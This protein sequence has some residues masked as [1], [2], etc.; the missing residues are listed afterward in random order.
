MESNSAGVSPSVPL[1]DDAPKEASPKLLKRAVTA[2]AMGNATEWFDYGVYAYLA[3][4]IGANFFPGEHEAL[5]A[6]LGLAVS[7]VL[8]PLGGLV[9]GP[10]GDR[11]GRSKVLA[12]TILLM[13]SATFLMGLLPT[14]DQIGIWA[15]ILLILLRVVQGFSTG[16]EYGGAATFMAEYAPDKKRGFWGSFLEF[17]T[18][19]GLTAGLIIVAVLR[20]FLG[21][22]AM[23]DWGWRIPFLVAGPL[24]GIG[25]YLRMKM[26][27]TPVFQELSESGESEDEATGALKNLLKEHW[28]PILQLFGLVIALNVA[29]YLLLTYM[30]TYLP[31]TVGMSKGNAEIMVLIGQVVM[32]ILLPMAGALSDRIGR[33]PCWWISLIG[34]FVLSVPMFWL[35]GKGMVLAVIGFTVLGA[36]YVLQ[37]G[38]ISATFPAMFPSHVR[39]AGMAISYN[40][41]TAAFGGTAPAINEALIGA[42]GNPLIPAFYMMAACAV[43]MVALHFVIETKGASLRGRGVPGVLSR[44]AGRRPGGGGGGLGGGGTRPGQLRPTTD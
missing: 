31:N 21:D 28:K 10:L 20:F 12:T 16:G 34:L 39:Y 37:L 36:I 30:P 29:N 4:E 11:L 23:Q 13:C 40:V 42:T 6:L 7:F 5:G 38:T 25:L 15:P 26:E 18:L 3:T 14:F 44:P 9:W 19:A 2:S 35:M 41:A 22:A 1:N 24:G 27:D 17:G 43:A 32:M 8:R 33:K